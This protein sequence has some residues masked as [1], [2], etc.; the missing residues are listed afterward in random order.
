MSKP[1]QNFKEGRFTHSHRGLQKRI[2]ATYK[3]ESEQLATP[4]A[5]KEPLAPQLPN[6]DMSHYE[7]GLVA[8]AA[9]VALVI[10]RGVVWPLSDRSITVSAAV[11]LEITLLT[12]LIGLPVIYHQQEKNRQTAE[13]RMSS[14]KKDLQEYKTKEAAYREYQAARE[15]FLRSMTAINLGLPINVV[16]KSLDNR[17]ARNSTN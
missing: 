2:E 7:A 6:L 3:D 8:T 15:S 13:I 1:S 5:P 14:F 12:I 9:I 16:D 4:K 10:S 17:V 11:A